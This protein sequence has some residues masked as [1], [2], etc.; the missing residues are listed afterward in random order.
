MTHS[1]QV[2]LLLSKN[3]IEG[4][5]F[6]AIQAS[7]WSEKKRKTYWLRRKRDEYGENQEKNRLVLTIESAHTW[8]DVVSLRSIL[9][10][11]CT[12]TLIWR[13]WERSF[14]IH[15]MRDSMP[16]GKSCFSISL[17]TLY[18]SLSSFIFLCSHRILTVI[19]DR[20]NRHT[21]KRK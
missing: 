21:K 8:F 9:T 10:F 6:A 17:W 14:D 4:V 2:V 12:S 11:A 19:I 16:A 15:L 7:E 13:P 5:L 18:F 1:F 3:E 20:S